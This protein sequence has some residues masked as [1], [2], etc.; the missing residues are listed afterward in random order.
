[1]VA[2]QPSRSPASAA[3]IAPLQTLTTRR[4]LG[5][6][7]SIQLIS[8]A[9]SRAADVPKPPGNTTVSN[10]P[11]ASGSGLAASSRPVPV[12]TGAPSTDTSDTS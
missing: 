6:A 11:E 5:A 1:V 3:S 12:P 4:A 8:V 7:I 9:S 2:A 10:G